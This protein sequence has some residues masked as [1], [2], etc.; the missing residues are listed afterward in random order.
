MINQGVIVN[1]ASVNSFFHP[2]GL[3]IDYG[4]AKAALLNIAK[5]LSQGLGPK[6]A[7]Q[8]LVDLDDPIVFDICQANADRGL[9]EDTAE[10]FLAFPDSG[11]R[12]EAIA[13]VAVKGRGADHLAVLADHGG[14][15]DRHVQPPSTL[16]EA[17]R[18]VG[19]AIPRRSL[20]P[21]AA[22]SF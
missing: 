13:D 19:A 12:L 4:A 2:D 22:S 20:R 16:A 8:R 21:V 5:A 10:P 9:L 17:D 18:L 1:V 15:G 6:D 14:D 3:V 11:F 7:A